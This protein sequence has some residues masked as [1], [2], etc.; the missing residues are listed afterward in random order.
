MNNTIANATLKTNYSNLT[1]LYDLLQSS[2]HDIDLIKKDD[3]EEYKHLLRTIIVSSNTCKDFPLITKEKQEI[4]G[5]IRKEQ[6]GL[7]TVRIY[8]DLFL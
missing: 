5:N 8:I 2:A 7:D 1:L 3:E 6:I 4:V